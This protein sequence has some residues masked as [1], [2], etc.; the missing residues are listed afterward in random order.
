MDPLVLVVYSYVVRNGRYL[1]LGFRASGYL[2]RRSRVS[3]VWAILRVRHPLLAS[4][5]EM[6]DYNDIRFVYV[7]CLSRTMLFL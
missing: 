5:I 2:V 4:K 1:H 7:N 6:Y 3:L